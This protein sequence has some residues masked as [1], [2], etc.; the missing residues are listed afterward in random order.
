MLHLFAGLDAQAF[1]VT[2]TDLDGHN[3]LSFAE[4]GQAMPRLLDVAIRN[5]HDLIVR[6]AS[7]LYFDFPIHDPAQSIQ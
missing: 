7:F 3:A 1:D 2:T 4:P 5:R 6:T